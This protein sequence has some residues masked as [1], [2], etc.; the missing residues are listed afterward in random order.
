MTVL[1]YNY[2]FGYA[3]HQGNID[4]YLYLNPIMKLVSRNTV[5]FIILKM[6]DRKKIF[7][8]ELAVIPS[9]VCLTLDMWTSSTSIWILKK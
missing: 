6:Y 5:K 4:I 3:E 8:D 9:R 7:T 2:P 1:K